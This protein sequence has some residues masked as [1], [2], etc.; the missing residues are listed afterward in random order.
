M[1]FWGGIDFTKTWIGPWPLAYYAM[2]YVGHHQMKLR[3][4]PSR[5]RMGKCLRSKKQWSGWG[6]LWSEQRSSAP[7]DIDSANLASKQLATFLWL[8]VE[9]RDM[10]KTIVNDRVSYLE[11]TREDQLGGKN[12]RGSPS[13]HGRVQEG[14]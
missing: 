14:F 10:S 6:R 3:T 13:K 2:P 11:E 9:T 5:R 12:V 4:K 8:P 7:D 1:D